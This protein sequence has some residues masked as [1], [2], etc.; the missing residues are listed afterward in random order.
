MP[1]GIGTFAIGVG[2]IGS[3]DGTL[4]P[5]GYQQIADIDSASTL[6][7]PSGSS[8]AI[9]VAEAADVRYRDDGGELTSSVGMP[10]AIGFDLH[11]FGD[12]T[13]LRFV[14]QSP[15][16]IINILYYG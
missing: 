6:D 13:L 4:S 1:S 11:Y 16:A 7:V 5:K 8:F 9:I 3:A 15:G 10:L 14:G 12:P 2:G